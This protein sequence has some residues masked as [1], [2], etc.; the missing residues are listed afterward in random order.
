MRALSLC[1]RAQLSPS[2]IV[3]VCPG[4]LSPAKPSQVSQH[5]ECKAHLN[6]LCVLLSHHKPKIS[7][8]SSS[9]FTFYLLP[10]N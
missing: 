2:L 8:K 4:A 9:V 7:W 5:L 1:Q 10:E 3:L 6:E